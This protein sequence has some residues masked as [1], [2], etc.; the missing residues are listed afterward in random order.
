MLTKL[1][2]VNIGAIGFILQ[3]EIVF[4]IVL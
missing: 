3:V 1:N 2:I 4:S